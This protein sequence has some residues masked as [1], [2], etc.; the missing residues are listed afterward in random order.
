L[1]S[2]AKHYL[3]EP[4]EPAATL[5]RH[6]QPSKELPTVCKNQIS[7]LGLNSEQEQARESNPSRQERRR[8]SYYVTWIVIMY[9]KFE[10]RSLLQNILLALDGFVKENYEY[11]GTIAGTQMNR[12][13][14]HNLFMIS[15]QTNLF[16]AN[17]ATVI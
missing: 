2:T 1:S 9:E 11:Y 3:G 17:T 12:S 6:D 7:E 4:R 16:H 14:I 5:Q 10:G 15:L 8:R 13:H